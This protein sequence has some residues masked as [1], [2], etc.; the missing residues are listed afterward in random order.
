MGPLGP[1]E[2]YKNRVQ[3]SLGEAGVKVTTINLYKGTHLPLQVASILHE[4]QC[5]YESCIILGWGSGDTSIEYEFADNQD[6]KKS[7]ISWVQRGGRF[8]IQG[9]GIRKMNWPKWFGKDTWQQGDYYRT[10]HACYSN[11]EDDI[12]WC[13][14]YHKAK[15]AKTNGGPPYNV[16]AVMLKGVSPEETLFG[17]TENSRSYSLVPFMR[18]HEIG[19][20]QCAIAHG[21]F[22]EGSISFFGDVNAE[23]ET[24]DIIAVIARGN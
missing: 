3:Q 17:T 15:G 5:R 11:S 1:G 16:K 24:C 10:D 2:F 7:I 19:E 12:H 22:G 14:W 6:F 21:Q 9:E 20:G 13:K 8:I 18:D 4:I 23:Q